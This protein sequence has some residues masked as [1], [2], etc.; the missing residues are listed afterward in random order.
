MGERKNRILPSS[1]DLKDVEYWRKRA[2]EAHSLAGEMQDDR[3]KSL[4]LEIAES[5]QQ[6]A[7]SCEKIANLEKR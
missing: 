5:Y 3:T 4:M 2:K 6:I 7:K 1:L